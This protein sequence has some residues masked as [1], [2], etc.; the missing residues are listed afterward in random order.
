MSAQQTMNRHTTVFVAIDKGD[1][2]TQLPYYVSLVGVPGNILDVAPPI[3]DR[4]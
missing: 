2:V 1:A 4:G 3:V